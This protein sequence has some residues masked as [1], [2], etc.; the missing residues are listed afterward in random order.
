MTCL[1]LAAS[2]EAAQRTNLSQLP[3]SLASRKPR[4]PVAGALTWKTSTFYL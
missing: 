3:Y 2:S 1:T 4:I